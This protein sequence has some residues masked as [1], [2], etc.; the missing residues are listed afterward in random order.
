MKIKII[1]AVAE[2]GVI[3]N[4]PKIPWYIPE[5]FKHFKELTLGHVVVMGETT[6]RSMGKAL[7]HR[8]NVV[9]SFDLKELPDAA[10]FNTYEEGLEHAK[11]YAIENN[12][13][14]F[15]IGGGSIYQRGIVDTEELHISHIPGSYEGDIFFPAFENEW[16]IH[17]EEDRGKF[18][19]RIW[20]RK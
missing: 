7:P 5:D 17:K 11:K 20:V 8:Y 2:N 16:N 15:I 10:V 9:L 1:A 14:V 4:G 3:G 13:D 6:Y 12:C 18:I 19:Y